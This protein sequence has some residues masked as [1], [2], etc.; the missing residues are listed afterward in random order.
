MAVPVGEMG[1]E[2]VAPTVAQRL[3]ADVLD[4]G[5]TVRQAW[6]Q[7]PQGSIGYKQATALVRRA[8]ADRA[9]ATVPMLAARILRI[10]AAEVGAIERRRDRADVERLG[11][12]A[13]TLA[14][15]QK[16]SPTPQAKSDEPLLGLLDSASL[17]AEE[18]GQP[19]ASDPSPP[20]GRDV[21]ELAEP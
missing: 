7:L 2:V 3:A 21:G 17:R 15:L 16:L 20:E 4:R 8:R 11:R 19:E 18:E 12:I 13:R 14:D 10:L 9:Q 1:D 5:L 6:R